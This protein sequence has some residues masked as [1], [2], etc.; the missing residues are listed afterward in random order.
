MQGKAP[1][2]DGQSLTHFR[3]EINVIGQLMGKLTSDI[4]ALTEYLNTPGAQ[5]N[6]A[7]DHLSPSGLGEP[8]YPTH[9]ALNPLEPSGCL[10]HGDPQPTQVSQVSE[11]MYY[12]ADTQGDSETHWT[13]ADHLTSGIGHCYC[14]HESL[15]FPGI[16]EQV[17]EPWA[18]EE[19]GDY[20]YDP[21]TQAWGFNEPHP[22]DGPLDPRLDQPSGW[23]SHPN[24][25][26]TEGPANYDYSRWEPCLEETPAE[27]HANCCRVRWELYPGTE[28]ADTSPCYD[29]PRWERYPDETPAEDHPNYDPSRW[30]LYP[31]EE[32]TEDR[33]NCDPSRWEL[34]PDE[35]PAGGHPNC[36]ST[37]WTLY[38]DEKPAKAH[39]N[40]DPSRWELY[41]DVDLTDDLDAPAPAAA[42]NRLHSGP[43]G[44]QK[45]APR[46]PSA[47]PPADMPG[48]N[49]AR[50][51]PNLTE[52]A[53]V[54]GLAQDLLARGRSA[55]QLAAAPA[56]MGSL[57]EVA[58]D[59]GATSAKNE[60]ESLSSSG[61]VGN[62][63]EPR[64]ILTTDPSDL[65]DT[66]A[67]AEARH[68]LD[69]WNEVDPTLIIINSGSAAD[70]EGTAETRYNLYDL[71]D[72]DADAEARQR[73]ST[74]AEED[75]TMPTHD[76]TILG[77]AADL[78]DQLLV[79]PTS[80]IPDLEPEPSP[81][82][83]RT[84]SCRLFDGLATG[85]L[86]LVTLATTAEAYSTDLLN[87]TTV[88]PGEPGIGLRGVREPACHGAG[89]EEALR[90][91]IGFLPLLTPMLASVIA[92]AQPRNEEETPVPKVIP[93]TPPT[94]QDGEQGKDAKPESRKLLA[95]IQQLEDALARR[96][97]E[98]HGVPPSCPLTRATMPFF[99]ARW[100]KITPG[101]TPI[102]YL[103]PNLTIS[104]TR[105][106]PGRTTT[107][108]ATGLRS[109]SSNRKR[110]GGRASESPSA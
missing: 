17:A 7:A 88:S 19:E 109:I 20:D 60:A 96:P 42:P 56:P 12:P 65:R 101:T 97:V 38:P 46:L 67:D 43:R 95:R 18:D 103:D 76:V 59:L 5:G 108:Y 52:T 55:P 73:L 77:P 2:D 85:T 41:P 87:G 35:E 3:S 57:A 49:Q 70:N 74:W 29:Y 25:E 23:C 48:P 105:W 39:A 98:S 63:G 58:P 50:G 9:W 31:D 54:S 10:H 83:R 80:P 71:G 26:V 1:H 90:M 102:R 69:R 36:N 72:S 30:E 8:P 47:E 92:W 4:S 44:E 75:P 68:H 11:L 37:R 33:P 66:Y 100:C 27:C 16:E 15:H 91:S 22:W 51:G 28:A 79:T 34:Y 21:A 106:K 81:K 64:E 84:P 32:P 107:A 89:W 104:D 24:R 53:C 110:W 14:H 99:Q 78:F 61:T 45:L 62:L 94:T 82:R 6:P 13:G 86:A 93:T 40:H